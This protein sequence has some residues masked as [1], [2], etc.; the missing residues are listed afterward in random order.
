LISASFGMCESQ[1]FRS[2]GAPGDAAGWGVGLLIDL[3]ESHRRNIFTLSAAT[4]SE[5]DFTN[6]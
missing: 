3:C 1:D 2:T 5:R 6:L 4:D